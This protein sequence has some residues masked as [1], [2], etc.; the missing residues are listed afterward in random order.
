MTRAPRIH[1]LG[2]NARESSPRQVIVIDTETYAREVGDDEHHHMHTWCA[3]TVRRG[4]QHPSR[5]RTE[6]ADGVTP[7]QLAAW[8]EGQV[9][10]D[11]PVWVYM[12]NLSFD[13]STTR[14]PL[15]L[16]EHGWSV[17]SHNLASDAPWAVLRKGSKTIRLADSYSM[18]PVS[19]AAIAARMG[20][21]KPPLPTR[22]DSHETWVARGRADVEIVMAALV[23][24]MDWWDTHRLGH[25]SITG[26]RTGFNAMRHRCVAR[27]GYDPAV[28]QVGPGSPWAQLGDGH[29]VID[30][31]PEARAFERDTLYQGRREAYRL[32]RLER[33]MYTEVDMRRAHLTVART[34]RLPHRRGVGFD[35]LPYD[36]PF[37]DGRSLSVI[38]RCRLRTEEARY[39]V[40]TRYGIIHPVGEFET[41]LAGPEIEIARDRGHLV[42]IGSGYYYHLSYHMQP[43]A[44]WA[45]QVMADV[46]GAHP[47][48]A[49]IAVKGWTRSVPGTWAAR[50][51]RTLATGTSPVTGWYAEPGFLLSTGAP[52]TTVHLAGVMQMIVRDVESDDS[53]PAVLSFIQAHTRIALN[54]IMDAIPDYRVV[55][56]STDSILIDGSGWNP[57]EK[58]TKRR[59]ELAGAAQADAPGLLAYLAPAAGEHTLVVKGTA[60]DVRVLSP[61]HVRMD[62]KIKYSGIAAGATETQRDTFT[63]HTWPKLGTQM[64]ITDQ[65]VFVR[66][67][68]EVNL[69]AITVPRWTYECG[70][71]QAP[72]MHADQPGV[73]VP[74]PDTDYC[75]RHPGAAL[76]ARQH[77]ALSRG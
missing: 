50:T 19:V 66:Q 72:R 45:E 30:P 39:P 49:K 26:P 69:A 31:D 71:T 42:T 70:C 17:T 40:R 27:A 64:T 3:M 22:E 25:W 44:I 51:S 15:Y 41:V 46:S 75:I 59:G 28:Q 48:A 62:G 24:L 57:G 14:L 5:P 7:E 16:A 33:G 56:C 36:T 52:C 35:H 12:H 53:F 43:W 65:D 13:L 34:Q 2:P 63:F 11:P 21:V 47:E 9:K 32:G 29:V 37:L 23:E 67:R 73:I 6:H 60:A 54:R 76:T 74:R 18:L 55:T 38:A 4:T 10:S 77:P 8:L 20:M 61:Q 68:R 1:N 58:T